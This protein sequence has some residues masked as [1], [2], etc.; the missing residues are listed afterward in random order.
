MI[1]RFNI[2][3]FYA[4]AFAF[5]SPVF[6]SEP[7]ANNAEVMMSNYCYSCHDGDSEKG[8]IRLDNLADLSLT[9]RLELLNKVKEQTYLKEMPP[10]KEKNQ[11]SNEERR[12][13][14]AGVSAELDK[15]DASTLEEKLTYHGY[16]NYV[17]H[18][19]LFSGKVEAKPY[20]PARRWLVSP[21][22]FEERVRDVF[23]LEGRE[24][25]INLYGV[26][27][28]FVL[29]ER[30]GIR[31]FANATLDGGHLLSM[32]SNAKW[33]AGKQTFAARNNNADKN[34]IVYPNPKDKWYPAKTPEAFGLIISKESAPTESEMIA[35]IRAQFDCVLRREPTEAELKKYLGL[36]KEGIEV[37]GNTTGL[38]Q[39]LVTV[40][41]ESEFLYRVEFGE[42]DPDQDGR[43]KLSPREASYAISYS[44]G[45]RN[46][47]ALLTQAAAEGRLETKADYRRE[48]NRLFEDKEYYKGKIDASL[49]GKHVRSLVMSHPK[50]ARFFRD[51][52]GYPAALR[53]F[54]DSPRSDGYY[55]NPCRS[56]TQTPGRLISEADRIIGWYLEK[57]EN[58]FENILTT[59]Q[60]FVYHDRDAEAG[61]KI[62]DEWKVFFEKL[63]DTNWRTD[64]EKVYAENEEYIKSQ[65]N[66][67]LRSNNRWK[68]SNELRTYM[69]FFDEYFGRGITPFT[70]VPWAHGYTFHHST[71][72][73]LPPTPS[74]G[75]Y[76][77]VNNKNFK[78][79]DEMN[80][81]D[82]PVEQPFK[83]A[84]R[85]GILTHPAWLVAHSQ[86]TATDPVKRGLWIREKLLAGH[87]PD[88]PITVDAQV[89]EDPPHTLR[90]R[91]ESVTSKKEC[92]KCHERMNPLG[93]AFEMFDDFGRFRVE[94]SLEHPDNF[95]AKTT[96]HN[97]ADL[98]KT[99]P[100]NSTGAL[101]GTGDP[102]LDGE[103]EDALEMIDRLAKSD[104]ARQSIIRHAFRFYMGRNEMLSDSQTLID[105]DRA[106]LESSGSFKAIVV[107]FLTSDSFMYR[108]AIH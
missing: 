36:T 17:D 28:P 62:I 5:A 35:A 81:W 88:V 24:R 11:P 41:L 20:T 95:I 27:N 29:P 23:R 40:L 61:G 92:W 48:V 45:D 8:D 97:G 54:K 101:N 50:L 6:A 82:Y 15:H 63:K 37:A 108:K 84:N 7:A 103:V 52:F 105:A 16:G 91:L 13:L 73:S 43:Q 78:G 65:K 33:I 57:D 14:Y 2:S 31:D 86:N 59:E 106:Y 44:L 30:S 56:G 32:L 34:K 74:I 49:E 75:R 25:N 64:P 4:V 80:F 53:V 12:Q 83:I 26:T 10:K 47:D 94:E 102:A 100:V 19:L 38:Q 96:R 104:R 99:K 79:Y 72:Y 21:A 9:N 98:Y 66:I 89:P 46:P 67:N 87:V 77:E 71:F 69:T 70:T 55:R 107:S 51:F 42:G 1:E 90:E 60:F 68:V 76:Y 18:E 58:V 85:K 3:L 93:N 39:M 22:I